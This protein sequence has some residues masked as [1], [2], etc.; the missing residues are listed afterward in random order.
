MKQYAVIGGGI[1]GLASAYYLYQHA[2]AQDIP[3]QVTVYERDSTWGGVITS[4]SI[5][6]TKLYD[7]YR[8]P[9]PGPGLGIRIMGEV[10]GERLKVL[11]QADV[12]V[13]E[14]MKKSGYYRKV[15][16][17]FAVLLPIQTVSYNFV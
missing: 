15:W 7:I 16:Q 4:Y 17:S 5:H 9:F 6:Y 2:H 8:Q 3:I 11:R 1:A 14:E 12:I 10:T 13:L